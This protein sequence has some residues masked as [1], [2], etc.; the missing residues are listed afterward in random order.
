[1][2]IP[3]DSV[4]K[5]Q[6]RS[7]DDQQLQCWV[8]PSWSR[9]R[10]SDSNTMVGEWSLPVCVAF[11]Q[12]WETYEKFLQHSWAAYRAIQEDMGNR[13]IACNPSVQVHRIQHHVYSANV[14]SKDYDPNGR[15]GFSVGVG[16]HA[17][18]ARCYW[19]NAGGG[20]LPS[21]MVSDIRDCEGNWMQIP[22]GWWYAMW[23]HHL[24][25]ASEPLSALLVSSQDSGAIGKRLV[26]S[27]QWC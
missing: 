2:Q 16:D 13:W 11:N 4:S 20:E 24:S 12:S 6:L 17:A 14:Y 27:I 8:H 25:H 19:R 23:F 15:H 9:C 26:F 22:S 21:T 10:W 7:F 18:S 1:M 5:T 3:V